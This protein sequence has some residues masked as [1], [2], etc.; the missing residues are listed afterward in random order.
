MTTVRIPLCQPLESRTASLAKDAR[1]SNCYFERRGSQI[2]EFVS[3]PGYA[4]APVSPALAASTGQGIY[5]FNGK[6][7]VVINN[8]LSE[9]TTGY[10]SSTK[11]T[12]TGTVAPVYFAESSNN[13]ALF[14]HNGTNGYVY[15]GTTLAKVDNTSVY[16]VSITVGGSGY[17][18]PTVTFS[19]PTSGTTAT[20]TVAVVGGVVTGVTIVNPGTGYTTVPSVTINPV[21]GGGGAVAGAALIGFPTG[22]LAAGAV[23]LDGYTLVATTAGQIYNSDI[24]SPT[25]WNALNF[26]SA[27]ADP[28]P[29]VGIVKHFNY[30]CV[31]GDWGSEFFYD[32]AL[33]PGTPFARNDSYKCEIGCADGRSIASLEQAV[34]FV[35]K[36]KTHG[37]SVYYLDGMTP[38]VISTRYVEKYLNAETGSI[39][40][41]CFKIAGHTFYLITL[42]VQDITLVYDFNEKE[43]V[44]WS[45]YYSS[46]EHAYRVFKSTEFNNTTIGLDVSN[47]SLYNISTA[48]TADDAIPIYCRS[49]TS[50]LD[51]GSTK[52]KFF[53]RGEMV[54]DKCSATMSIRWSANDYTTFSSYRTVDLSFS[55]PTLY[56]QGSSRRRSFEFYCP[57]TVA[58]RIEAWECE[59]EGGEIENDPALQGR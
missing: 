46:A 43:W 37:K 51:S 15:N 29:I 11:G 47:G 55:R 56:Q 26:L 25:Q 28:D 16:K 23:Y 5:K 2:R 1:S 22:P 34:V 57:T 48:Y 19:P 9:V 14:M 32:A 4:T 18:T 52:R 12:L 40:G 8:T 44:N 39:I 24:E 27:E 45:S 36:S 49:V 13:T 3:R 10:A 35:G 20:G 21:G 59:V 6:L 54:G 50:I 58:L 31:F 7:S 17:V 38:N 42:E 41:E 33:S 30:L 53:G